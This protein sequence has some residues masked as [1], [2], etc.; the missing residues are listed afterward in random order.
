MNKDEEKWERERE[1]D[2]QQQKYLS[3]AENEQ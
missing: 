1:G 3:R 2:T